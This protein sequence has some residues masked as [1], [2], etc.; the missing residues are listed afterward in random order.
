MFSKGNKPTPGPS[1]SSKSEKDKAYTD[2]KTFDL[3][4]F[5]LY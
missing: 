5:D 2:C 3:I 4:L 1:D